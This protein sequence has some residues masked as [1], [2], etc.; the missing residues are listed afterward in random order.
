MVGGDEDI[1]KRFVVAQQHV[2]ARPQPF[3]QIG[4]EQEGFGLGR[5]R[6]E[7]E[8]RSRGD[9]ALDARIVAGRTGIGDDP[10]ADVLR[11]A[12]IEHV[13]LAI[14]HAVDAGRGRRVLGMTR[15][16]CPAHRQRPGASRK[17]DRRFL[18]GQCLLV[19]LFD[20]LGGGID[21]VFRAVHAAKVRTRHGLGHPPP[22]P[23]EEALRRAS[24]RDGAPAAGSVRYRGARLRGTGQESRRNCEA[25]GNL[26]SI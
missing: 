22:R 19:V 3:D 24:G 12:D 6:N 10:F 21:V 25:P 15:D 17:V 16:D 23:S 7:L 13:T 20:E 26:R 11:L 1:G 5:G 9:H 2:E 4:F 8:R 18:F 14:D